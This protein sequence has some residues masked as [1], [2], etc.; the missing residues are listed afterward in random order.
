MKNFINLKLIFSFLL[1]TCPIIS[2]SNPLVK[3]NLKI[4]SSHIVETNN[5]YINKNNYLENK[6]DSKYNYQ[7][8]SLKINNFINQ[9]NRKN[10]NNKYKINLTKDS[11]NNSFEKQINSN[12]KDLS[13]TYVSPFGKHNH[14]APDENLNKCKSKECFE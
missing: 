6:K 14:R 2:Y 13:T 9:N 5:L 3:D 10:I 4:F 1:L 11:L 8:N 12:F 7:N